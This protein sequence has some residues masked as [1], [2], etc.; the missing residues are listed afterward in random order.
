MRRGIVPS[1]VSR[2]IGRRCFHTNARLE[3][4]KRNPYSQRPATL[5]QPSSQVPASDIDV[6]PDHGLYQFFREHKRSLTHLDTIKTYGIYTAFLRRLTV[7]RAWT[8]EELRR[9][10]WEDL[11]VL[12]YKCLLERNVMSTE[13]L[14]SRKQGVDYMFKHIHEFRKRPVCVARIQR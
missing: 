7:G 14:E 11:H 3:L 13:A 12:W 6:D 10:S 8:A 5:P 2:G 1:F 4:P 9:K